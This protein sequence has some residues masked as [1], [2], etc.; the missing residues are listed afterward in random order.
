MST[1]IAVLVAGFI[2]GV[3]V[4]RNNVKTVEKAVGEALEL[5]D[6]AQEELA[7]LKTKA[8]KPQKKSTKK[9][10]KKPQVD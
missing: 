7:E 5:Y 6:K 4:G 2:T 1:L 9:A 10:V 3:L 8:R